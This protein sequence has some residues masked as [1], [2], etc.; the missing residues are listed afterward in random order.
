MKLV[1]RKSILASASPPVVNQCDLG[2]DMRAKK[3]LPAAKFE[4]KPFDIIEKKVA[5]YI[6]ADEVIYLPI[7][8]TAKAFA[9]EPNDFYYTPFGGPHP[10]RGKQEVFPKRKNKLVGNP[11][12]CILASG[13]GTNLQ[14][15]IEA[16]ENGEIEAEI[17]NVISNNPDA[18][19]LKRTKKHNIPTFVLPY[20]G[21]FSDK[22]ARKLYEEELIKHIE[23]IKPDLI[24]LAGWNFILGE[25][26]L[27]AMQ[28]KEIPVINQ[29]PALLTTNA[30]QNVATSQGI[31]PVIRGKYVLEDPFAQGLPVSGFTVHQLLPED[32]FDM[33]PV[34]LT[35]EVHRQQNDTLETWTKRVNEIQHL[36]LP[37]AIKRILHVMKQ[38]IDISKGDFPW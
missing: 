21:K 11:K 5:E 16:I 19:V 13:G 6:G 7:E 24:Q 14:V 33:G 15:M 8:E 30:S 38:N 25:T 32:D 18:Y 4:K 26:F 1:Q 9:G 28:K 29:H 36:F 35:A 20:K 34:I 27:K 22:E 17:V 10:I 2:I 3:E 12:I 31:I 37:T 23:Q